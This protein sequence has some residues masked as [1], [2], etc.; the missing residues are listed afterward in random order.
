MDDR[1]NP[2]S[3]EEKL[4][5]V[6]DMI[7]GIESGKLP[8]EESVLQYEKGM[9]ILSELDEALESMNRR[10]TALHDGKETEIENSE[11]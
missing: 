5:T 9:K 7:A 10:I 6:Q 3:F 8:L 4:Q 11:L 1:Q 2:A